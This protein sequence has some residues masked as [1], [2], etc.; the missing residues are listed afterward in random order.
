MTKLKTKARA[1]NSSTFQARTS[2]AQKGT[3]SLS[4]RKAL[5]AKIA[6]GGVPQAER[7]AYFVELARRI[8]EKSLKR[9]CENL[10]T[11]GEDAA[12]LYT[13]FSQELQGPTL[14]EAQPVQQPPVVPNKKSPVKKP[15][16][17]GI[18]DGKAA[19][20][21]AKKHFQL[22]GRRPWLPPSEPVFGGGGRETEPGRLVH[23]A[24]P[25]RY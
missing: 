1:A 2:S 7:D 17:V 9:I 8:P 24:Q 23:H 5:F 19:V 6:Q 3:P 14:E 13:I 11:L 15:K 4:E 18:T 21:R 10:Q 20:K 12:W 25:G 22:A 16:V